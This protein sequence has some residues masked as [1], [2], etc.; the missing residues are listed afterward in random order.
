[1]PSTT[2]SAASVTVFSGMPQRY[3]MP[4]DMK[5]DIGI[6]SAATMADRSGKRSIITTM[7]M[8]M[9]TNRSRRNEC[10]ESPPTL[11]WSAMRCTLT[12]AGSSS[13][14]KACSTSST[15]RPYSTM[16]FPACISSDSSTQRWPLLR[17]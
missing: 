3:I 1:M 4:T 2:T 10:T 15:S 6:V 16:L 13:S 12:S 7:M 5:V 17:I 11:A 9:A 8:A 14:M